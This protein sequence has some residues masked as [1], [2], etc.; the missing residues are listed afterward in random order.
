M[1]SGQPASKCIPGAVLGH[2]RIIGEIGAGGM[3]IVYK[4]LDAR[5]DRLV[6]LKVLPA[7]AVAD[8]ERRRR[9]AQEAKA[10]SALNHPNIILSMTSAAP[11]AL[12]SLRWS[13]SKDVRWT[14][15][16]DVMAYR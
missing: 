13:T 10:A 11:K 3:G 1:I 8:T 9:F 4:C 6:A 12:S 7:E 2:Y 15:R 16:L 14:K 5:L